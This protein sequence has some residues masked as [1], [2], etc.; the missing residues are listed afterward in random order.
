M[1]SIP[2]TRE[3]AEY[4]DRRGLVSYSGERAPIPH[5]LTSAVLL[6]DLDGC[7]FSAPESESSLPTVAIG[8]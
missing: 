2:P 5:V 3:R 7:L 8:V 1:S 6:S 4:E